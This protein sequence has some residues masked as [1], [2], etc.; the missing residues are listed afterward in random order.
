M[1]DPIFKQVLTDSGIPTDSN[2]MKQEFQQIAQDEGVT[3]NNDSAY[4]P[5]WRLIL[6]IVSTPVVW[7]LGVLVDTV[8]PNSFVKYASGA[9]LDMLGWAVD[10]T[11][12]EGNKTQG[13]IIF[14]RSTVG[15]TQV[16][17][18]GTVVQSVPINGTV[19]KVLVD[20]DATFTASDS[21]L[22]VNVTAE[23]AGA[24]YNLAAGYFNTLAEPIS[25]ISS[26]TNGTG[27]ITTP[28]E[29]VESDDDY[30]LRIKNQFSAV[31]QYHTDAVY[32]S[33]IAGQI[34]F[35]ADRIYFEHNAPRGPGSANAFV[36]FDAD[37]PGTDYLESVNAYIADEG[38]HGHGDDLLV[39]ALPET[40]HT[41]DVTLYVPDFLT[42]TERTAL[43]TNVDQFIRQAF[44]ES[45]TAGWNPTQTRPWSRFSFSRLDQELHAQFSNIQSIAWGQTDIISEMNIPRLQALNITLEVIT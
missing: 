18:A 37:V 16:I 41:I 17:Q 23:N 11:R 12:K 42:D 26:V 33:M 31:N 43:Q 8:L 3:L 9:F 2:T 4:S 39:M 25:G 28:G 21:S 7:L 34:G 44:R 35:A 24:E 27:W 6:A 40:Q 32:R 36:L 15:Q 29:D 19:Y 14:E 22:A 5:F 10:L 30:R 13:V 38:N 20:E 45:S 1:S